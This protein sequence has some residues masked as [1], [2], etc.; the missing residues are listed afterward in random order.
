M[1]VCSILLPNVSPSPVRDEGVSWQRLD[2]PG[3]G[4]GGVPLG[5]VVNVHDPGLQGLR[6][7]V[8]GGLEEPDL[9]AV[10]PTWQLW[11]LVWQLSDSLPAVLP[12]L[13]ADHHLALLLLH[14]P[15]PLTHNLNGPF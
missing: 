2:V 14:A 3:L 10:L 13:A 6:G 5:D 9:P 11:Q 7:D 12:Q 4:Q 1:W 8:D 15:A